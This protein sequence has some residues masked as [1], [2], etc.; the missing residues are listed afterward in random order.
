VLVCAGGGLDAALGFAL[1]VDLC[2]RLDDEDRRLGDDDGWAVALGD[3]AGPDRATW[4]A[5]AADAPAVF[6]GFGAWPAAS[7]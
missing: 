6:A 2:D 3:G 7:A 1:G 5:D 4:R